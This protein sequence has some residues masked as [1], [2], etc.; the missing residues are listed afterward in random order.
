MRDRLDLIAKRVDASVTKPQKTK[1]GQPYML[2]DLALEI[3]NGTPQHGKES[4]DQVVSRIFWWVKNNI[5]YRQDP[6]DYDM[7]MTAGRTIAAGGSD[8][9]TLDTK[10]VVRSKA[11]GFYELRSLGELESMWPAYDALSYHFDENKWEFRPITGWHGKN[12]KEVCETRLFNGPPVRHTADHRVWWWDGQNSSKRVVCRELGSAIDEQR[13]YFRRVLVASKI[14]ALSNNDFSSEQNYLSGIYT[15]EG[16]RPSG[17]TKRG[18]FIAQDKEDVRAKIEKAL[19]SL[20]VDYSK[21]ARSVHASYYVKASKFGAWLRSH[22]GDSFDMTLP[23]EILSG[24]EQGIRTVMEAHGDGDGW[25]PK[26][27]SVWAKKVKAIHTTSSKDLVERLQL[28][29]MILGEPWYTQLQLNHQGAGHHPIYRYHRWTENTQTAR[30]GIPE[31]NG[32]GYSPVRSTTP[33]EEPERVACITV[34]GPSNFVLSNGMIVHN[35]DDHTILNAALLNSL[36]FR[37]G[38]KVISPDEANWHIYT[39]VGVYPFYKPTCIIPLDTTQPGSY[40]GWEPPPVQRRFGYL[41]D[42]EYDKAKHLRKI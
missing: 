11:T 5:E 6:A 27:D 18:A 17:R 34:G 36:G 40:P 38:A 23:P 42:F 29:S 16:Y 13:G 25:R 20:G 14:P 12:D 8:C 4:E 22:G 30:R 19:D 35:C 3:V 39:V 15:A 28:L 24:S 33:L 21:S 37:T 2:R 32:V 10:V 26:P 31:L 7:Y 1:D 41:V 9:F